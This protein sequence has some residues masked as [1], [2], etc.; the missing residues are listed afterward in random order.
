MLQ[1]NRKFEF[2]E[3]VLHE[4]G[5]FFHYTDL[6]LYLAT[7]NHF[8][9]SVDDPYNHYI[10]LGHRKFKFFSKP[11]GLI[12]PKTGK[13]SFEYVLSWKDDIKASKCA[14]TIKPLFG[15]GTKTKKGKVFNVPLVGT[16]V[17]VQ[18]SFIE[19][20]ELRDLFDLF[21]LHIDAGRFMPLLDM[22][23]SKIYQAAMHVRYHERHEPAVIKM[24]QS[25][26]DENNTMGD[27]KVTKNKE[28]GIWDMFYLNEPN[29]SVCG[30]NSKWVHGVK[31]YRIKDFQKRPP[32]DPLRH[33]KFE[34]FLHKDPDDMPSLE[35]YLDLKRDMHDTLIKLISLV[36][37]IEYVSD[38]YFDAER[39]FEY[40]GALP[41]WDYEHIPQP[42]ADDYV[43]WNHP[44]KS[45]S[46]LAYVANEPQ[47]CTQFISILESLEIPRST[48]WRHI[49]HWINE[50]ILERKRKECTYI[51]FS[52]VSL[53]RAIKEP[54]L[55]VCSFLNI[56]F[57][58]LWG[59]AIINSGII[60]TLRK[61]KQTQ[62]QKPVK[63]SGE[64]KQF[65]V[66]DDYRKARELRKELNADGVGHLFNIGIISNKS[67]MRYSPT[68]YTG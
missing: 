59:Q 45:L 63:V 2:A 17:Q 57:K 47:G 27:V 38:R 64:Q 42:N 25:I 37:P 44:N 48:L 5:C 30:I 13:V 19:L 33:P 26:E 52:S 32:S 20:H 35:Q 8:I 51:F 31:S 60:K 3:P 54:V 23:L 6:N 9:E 58:R 55:Q 43:L 41:K 14:F 62:T 49:D 21:L 46:V 18:S 50:G 66:V 36:G 61:P 1:T 4:F 29:L 16:Q 10:E 7:V 24:L 68:V 28:A 53:W 22:K 12:N 39:I 34:V 15:P 56:G 65:I 40:R 67:N 11:G